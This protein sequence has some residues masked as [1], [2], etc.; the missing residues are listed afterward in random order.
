MVTM[1]AAS[2]ASVPKIESVECRILERVACE[3]SE[4]TTANNPFADGKSSMLTEDPESEKSEP[5]EAKLTS[6]VVEEADA[7]A[8]PVLNM[9]LVIIDG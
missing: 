9:H 3:V 5:P 2:A 4:V 8:A 6:E 1:V 7:V